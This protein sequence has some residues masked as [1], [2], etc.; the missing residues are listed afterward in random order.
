IETLEFGREDAVEEQRVDAVWQRTKDGYVVEIGI[1]M[2]LVGQRVGVAIDD[3]DR[4]GAARTS[5]GTLDVS[6]LRA[7]GRLIAASPDLN[8]HLRQFAQPGVE[9]TVAS[10]TGAILTRLDARALPGD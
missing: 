5:Y 1:P 9:L 8:D 7:T 2:S 3:R 10:G 6:D 4:R